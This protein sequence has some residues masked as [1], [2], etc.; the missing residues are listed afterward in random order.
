MYRVMRHV[1]SYRDVT[2]HCD[3]TPQRDDCDAH[4]RSVEHHTFNDSQLA[5]FGR[6]LR[7]NDRYL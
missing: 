4:S 2:S 1:T 7:V 3:A 6:N 5:A